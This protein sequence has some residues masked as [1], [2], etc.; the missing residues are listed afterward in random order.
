MEYIYACTYTFKYK[1]KGVGRDTSNPLMAVT[2][3]KG[4]RFR[5][6]VG[7]DEQLSHFIHHTYSLLLFF[8]NSGNR[9]MYCTF[10]F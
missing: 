7:N 2:T 1:G 10:V 6:E 8:F 3:G 5:V 9:F 4:C